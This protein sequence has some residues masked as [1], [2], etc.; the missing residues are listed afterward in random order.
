MFD[1]LIFLKDKE[2]SEEFTLQ[3]TIAKHTDMRIE[4]SAT[5]SSSSVKH[6]SH[7]EMQIEFGQTDFE[8]YLGK[9]FIF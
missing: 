4:F 6:S 2:K 8:W 9:K 3:K 5:S 7:F 1:M